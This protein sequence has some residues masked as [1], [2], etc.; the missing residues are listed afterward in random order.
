ME[1]FVK[2]TVGILVAIGF[3]G[4]AGHYG[5]DAYIDPSRFNFV[6]FGIWLGISAVMLIL[7][8]WQLD[9][10]VRSRG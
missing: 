4:I 6:I 10:S 7:L 3:C 1:H 2:I 5:Y 8:K 9:F